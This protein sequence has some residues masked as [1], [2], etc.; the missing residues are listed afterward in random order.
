MATPSSRWMRVQ[1]RRRRRRRTNWILITTPGVA[2]R[3]RPH[4]F[5]F[6]FLSG[7]QPLFDETVGNDDYRIFGFLL[8]T[9]ADGTSPGA[10]VQSARRL[11]RRFSSTR[12]RKTR[13]PNPVKPRRVWRK[14]PEAFHLRQVSLDGPRGG[15]F[16]I[17][18]RYFFVSPSF[19][20]S[21]SVFFSKTLVLFFFC[22]EFSVTLPSFCLFVCFCLFFFLTDEPS[23]GRLPTARTGRLFFVCV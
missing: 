13:L 12:T 5:L 18:F 1:S 14:P 23:G 20:S 17:F 15:S 3:G 22:T 9:P 2:T 11:M 10:G 16:V 7:H 21:S 8:S 19:D 6:L 4:L